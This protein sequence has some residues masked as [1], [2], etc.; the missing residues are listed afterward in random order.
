M[1]VRRRLDLLHVLAATIVMYAMAVG[2]A[3][4]LHVIGILSS[5]GLDMTIGLALVVGAFAA[6]TIYFDVNAA[7]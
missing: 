5:S 2:A 3:V 1:S 4:L 6:A 7:P